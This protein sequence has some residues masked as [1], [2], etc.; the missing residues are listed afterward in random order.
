MKLK[1]L[2]LILCRTPVFSPDDQLDE[3]W[4]ELK[5][6]ITES[7]PSFAEIINQI[8][9]SDLN[10]GN[11]KIRFSVWKYFNRARYRAT[12][13]G[14]FAAFTLVGPSAAAAFP[15]VIN[16]EIRL[17]AFIDWKEKDNFIDELIRLKR[18]PEHYQSNTSLYTVGNENRYISFKNGVFEVASV[19]GFPELNAMLALCREKATREE[20]HHSIGAAFKLNKVSINKLLKQLVECQLLLTENHPNITGQ[21]YFDRLNPKFS[22]DSDP[23]IIAERSLVSGSPDTNSLKNLPDL[24]KLLASSLPVTTNNTLSNFRNAFLK[25]FEH[26]VVLLA[27]AMDPETGVGYGNLGDEP[28]ET[29]LDNILETV[30]QQKKQNLQITYSPLHRFLLNGLAKGKTVRLEEFEDFAGETHLPLPNTF[31]V[32]VHFNNGNPVIEHAGGCTANALLG[33]FTIA[34]EKIEALGLGIAAIEEQANPGILF[35]DIAYQAENQVDNVNRR[36][37]LYS[38]ELPILTWSTSSSPISF[39]DILVTV[40][41]TEV[42]LLSKK[43]GKRMVPRIATAYNYTRSDLAVYR[44]LCD[45]QHQQIRSDLNLKFQHIFPQ[46]DFYPRISYKDI[47]VSPATWKV[48]KGVLQ[49]IKSGKN[50]EKVH[51]LAKWLQGNAIDFPFKTGSSDQTLCFDPK[52]NGDMEAFLLYCRQNSA[53][54][55]YIAEALI[56]GLKDVVDKEGRKYA[57]QY[58]LSYCNNDAIYNT[59]SQVNRVA[60]NSRKAESAILPG[61]EWLYFEIYCHP[62][63]TNSLLLNQINDFIRD[64]SKA[65][66]KW[67]FI[68]YQEPRA[69]IRLRIQLNH[70]EQGYALM[71]GLKALLE[72]DC[73]NG[74]ISDIQVKTYFPETERYG[75]KR[76]DLIEKHFHI[77]SRYI[78]KLLADQKLTNELYAV[79]LLLMQDMLALYLGDINHQVAFAR[80][81]ADSFSRELN[82]DN[83]AFKKM[84]HGFQK[85]KAAFNLDSGTA[86]V[87][88]SVRQKNIA[89]RIAA[90]CTN[91]EER[92]RLLADLLHMHVNRLFNS[93]QRSH[94]AI[95]YHYLLKLLLTRRASLSTPSG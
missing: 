79:T 35:F 5:N 45:L 33:R 29:E 63:R 94:E 88:L 10:A 9:P 92:N 46:L 56:D 82:L 11:E 86:V 1:L 27:I 64:N 93:D 20:I 66:K 39:D 91:S 38:H 40:R 54:E 83:E 68:R 75:A 89:L 4:E 16:D 70:T 32:M 44:F 23:Y 41:G 47:I 19:P 55:L 28:G 62:A 59:F 52:N 65:I 7:S 31:S 17:K 24:F 12:P 77:D 61:G 60:E 51:E 3:K 71:G 69:H 30:N 48:P 81:V 73:L 15:V 74:L 42:I 85:L 14:G 84:N 80:E 95:L 6:L 53:S 67:F 72:E 25:K 78:L 90:T 34:N 18:A 26:R 13:F 58:I 2:N 50:D 57:A 22:P 49:N 36:K 37:Q 8:N 21:D 87:K 43:Y 76:M